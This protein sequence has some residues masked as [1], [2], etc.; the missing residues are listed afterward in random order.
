M[1]EIKFSDQAIDDIKNIADFI[2]NDS[3]K[4][5][6]IQT[7]R[8]FERIEILKTHPLS[9]R[10]VLPQIAQIYTDCTHR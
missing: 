7:N 9:G 4:Y 2:A 6:S 3:E 8:F 10:I 1:V 5:A